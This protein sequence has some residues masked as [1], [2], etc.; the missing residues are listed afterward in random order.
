MADYHVAQGES[1]PNDMETLYKDMQDGTHAVGVYARVNE[2]LDVRLTSTSVPDPVPVEVTNTASAAVPVIDTWQVLT[3]DYVGTNEVDID[4]D[5]NYEYQILWIWVSYTSD[6]NAGNRQLEIALLDT[7]DTL[8]GNIRV[9]AVQGASLDRIYMFGPALADLVAFRDTDWLMTP[10]PPTIFLP[11][12][13]GIYIFDN[14]NV[15]VGDNM[16]V[17]IQV[18]RRPV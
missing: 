8:I 17:Y 18:A 13:Y 2:P 3:L 4:V 15:S 12:G 6:A 7:I 5:P 14:N 11:A 1:V 9:G 16:I 10:L